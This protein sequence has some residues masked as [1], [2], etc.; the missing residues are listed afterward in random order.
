MFIIESTRIKKN[1][2][3]FKANNLNFGK[4]NFLKIKTLKCVYFDDNYR[5]Y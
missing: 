3:F 2:L 5:E 1:C 4:G